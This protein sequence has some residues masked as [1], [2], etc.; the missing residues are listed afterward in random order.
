MSLQVRVFTQG[1][2]I[3]PQKT[4]ASDREGKAAKGPTAVSLPGPSNV[5]S[6]PGLLLRSVFYITILWIFIY[7]YT[8]ITGVN[9]ASGLTYSP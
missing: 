6:F 8:V 2:S 3:S 7:I 1:L 5:V 4:A 9:R